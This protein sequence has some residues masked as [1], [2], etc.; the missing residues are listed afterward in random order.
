M[1]HH[2]L[3]CLLACLSCLLCCTVPSLVGDTARTDACD[4]T[5]EATA[6]ILLDLGLSKTY[7]YFPDGEL[8]GQHLRYPGVL[9]PERALGLAVTALLTDDTSEALVSVAGELGPASC[10][11]SCLFNR[12]SSIFGIVADAASNRSN[13]VL[14][15]PPNEEHLGQHWVFFLSITDLSEHGYWALVARDGSSVR[16]VSEN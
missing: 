11:A 16:V 3:A 15:L 6:A 10:D 14:P 2:F 13:R 8:R 5:S 9:C 4:I 7:T 12:E 1:P